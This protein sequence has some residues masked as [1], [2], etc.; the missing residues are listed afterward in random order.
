MRTPAADVVAW[1]GPAAGPEHYEVGADVYDAFVSRDWASG[2]AFR[3]T[4]PD[5]WRVDL[6]GLARRRLECAGVPAGQVHGGGLC[7]I[8]D[9]TRFFSHRRDRRAGRMAT[10]AWIEG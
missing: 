9:P 4:R 2:S 5:H 3:C 1:L 6:Y 10:L 7:T 8:A